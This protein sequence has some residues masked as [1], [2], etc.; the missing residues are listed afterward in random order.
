MR[1]SAST[2]RSVRHQERDA[3]DRVEW[4]AALW[5]ITDDQ[6]RSANP[7]LL[8]LLR[9]ASHLGA[10]PAVGHVARLRRSHSRDRVIKALVCAA[11]ETSAHRD[12]LY[13]ALHDALHQLAASAE[14][15]LGAGPWRLIEDARDEARRRVAALAGSL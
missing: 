8:T 15:V 1:R 12:A 3:I 5:E 11:Y 10:H 6:P 2:W 13:Y 14:D 7:D 4:L 9:F